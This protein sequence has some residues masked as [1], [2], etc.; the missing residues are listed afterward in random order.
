MEVLDAAGFGDRF[1]IVV[2][3]AARGDIV[4]SD[5]ERVFGTRA[6]AVLRADRAVGPAQDRG[7]L[8]SPRNSTA[9]ALDRLAASLR[10]LISRRDGA[11]WD[12]ARRLV[13]GARRGPT[14]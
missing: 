3:R 10:A 14:S 6:A 2:N 9:K 11:D 5:V 12:D 7:A 13:D 1:D 8:L 4:P